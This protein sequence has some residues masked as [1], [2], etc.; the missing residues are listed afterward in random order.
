MKSASS[1]LS[2]RRKSLLN[3]T[4]SAL[5]L[6]IGIV[7]PFFTG[8][9]QQIGK[10]LLPMHIPVL[11]CGLICGWSYGAAVGAV[12]PILRSLLFGMP[13]LYPNAVAMTVELMTYGLVVGFLFSH[14]RWQCVLSLYRSLIAAMLAGRVVWGITEIVLLG[15]G[16]TSF[17]WKAFIAGALLDAIPGII[18]QL[19]LIPAVMVAL[20]RAGLV[21]FRKEGKREKATAVSGSP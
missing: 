11:L 16:G 15:L 14:S 9:I 13:A 10:M 7:L 21:K 5:F 3:L 20:N 19:A 12:L 8:Q 4:L 6:A 2:K 18:L 17:T 1:T